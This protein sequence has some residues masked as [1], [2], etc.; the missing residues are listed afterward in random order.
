MEDYLINNFLDNNCE[1]NPEYDMMFQLMELEEDIA[2]DEE[3]VRACIDYEKIFQT[4]IQPENNLTEK[5]NKQHQNLTNEYF[6]KRKNDNH[7]TKK[8]KKICNDLQ[9]GNI[10]E[11]IAERN[12]NCKKFNCEEKIVDLKVSLPVNKTFIEINQTIVELFNKIFDEFIKNNNSQDLIRVYINHEMFRDG[13]NLP[14]VKRSELT[15]SMILTTFEN[16]IQSYKKDPDH[17]IKE[18]QK[19]TV[20]ILVAKLPSGGTKSKQDVKEKRTKNY[21]PCNDFQEFCLKK[22]CVKIIH[23]DDNLCLLKAIIIAKAY[24]DKEKKCSNFLRNNNIEIKKRVKKLADDLQIKNSECGIEELKKIEIYL[25]DYQ[26]ML[27]SN[28]GVVE[29]EPLYINYTKNFKKFLYILYDSVGKHYNVI[30]SMKAFRNC[31]YFCDFCKKGYSYVGNHNCCHLCISCKRHNCKNEEI[32]VCRQCGQK[33][34]NKT[35]KR[36]HS[37][38]ICPKSQICNKCYEKKNFY[39]VCGEREKWCGN[40]RMSVDLEHKCFIQNEFKKKQKEKKMEGY[41]FFDYEAYAN[42]DGIHVPNLII[43]QVICK[44]CV[45]FEERCERCVKKVFYNNDE[46]CSWL[47]KQ[48]HFIAIAHNLKGYDGAFIIQYIL[49]NL[50][51]DSPLPNCIFNGTKA[52]SI[53]YRGVVLKDSYSFIPMALS[54]FTKTFGLKELKK[55]FF[56][57]H[58]NKLENQSYIGKYPAKSDYG[59]EFFSKEKKVEFDTWYDKIKDQE[60]N[61]KTEFHDYCSSDVKLLTEGC[62]AFRKIILE[63]TKINE[64]DK[65]LEPFESSLTIASLCNKIF[66]RNCMEEKTLAIIPENGYNPEQKTSNKCRQWLKYISE[67]EKIHIQHAK[68]GG[69]VRADKYLLDGVCESNKTIYEFHGCMWHG[70]PKCYCSNGWNTIKQK[71]Y[72]SIYNSHLKRVETIKKLFPDYKLVEMWECEFNNRSTKEMS[73][74]MMCNPVPKSL[75]PRDALYGGRTNAFVLYYMCKNGQIIKY[76]DYTSLYPWAQKYG[77]YPIGHPEL[78]TENFGTKKYFGLIK[79]K[80]LPPRNLYFPVLPSR[81]NGK[82]VFTLCKLCA[83]NKQKDCTHT[84]QERAI[85]GTW[86]T[87]EVD[88]AIEN[89]YKIIETYEVWHWDE[90][91]QYDPKTKTGG[92]FT[93]YINTALKE[94]QEASGYPDGV[95]TDK[96]KNDY[97]QSYYENE[98]I[99]L[100]KEKIIKNS[101]KR[102]VAKLKANSQWGFLAMKTNKIQNKF[103]TNP[104][105]WYDMCTDPNISIHDVNLSTP[106]IIHVKYAVN[107]DV[108]SGGFN[109]NVAVASFVTCQARLKLFDEMK[110]LDRRVLY[111]DTDSIFFVSEPGAYEPELGDYLGEFTNE[112]DPREGSY[113]TE[114]VSAGPKNYAYKLDTGL[115]H[116]TVKG[117]SLNHIASLTVNYDSIKDIVCCEQ[118]KKLAVDQLKFK[119]DPK[120]W[121][122][123]TEVVNKIYGF[124]YDK[125]ILNDD[126]TTLPYGF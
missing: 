14:F 65:G 37:D 55:G 80:I 115:T 107:D 113:I 27:L 4:S 87:L 33:T 47:F 94:K 74:F 92:L 79:C 45:D 8:S 105:E 104:A 63:Q 5:I 23:N 26:I 32:E 48:K 82:L 101:G 66:R 75:D 90:R 52:I 125:R 121:T 72:G 97:I 20:S 102:S 24:A 44:K 81:I 114:F 59:S 18:H 95:I 12:V 25:K 86:V 19:L 118:D 6:K 53:E 98:G 89:N 11:K 68:N 62:L 85:E 17:L 50:L 103:L 67:T 122:V 106:N 58:F 15:P 77:I 83:Q 35:C 73:D 99:M 42:K 30:T 91:A 56:P 111:V 3:L 36:I 40:C 70:C 38:K 126:L 39:H 76:I 108:H 21:I 2:E 13:I 7:E 120:N 116:C 96:D 88:K 57:H 41:I 112:L 117:F 119:R 31:S 9:G 110:K 49:K 100:E 124:V 1:Y 22:R 71:S 93:K 16:V 10:Y 29:K 123:S 61:F 43:A 60:F 69:E 64:N 46:F 78:I 51:P 84:D 34:F 54:G 109:T 28:E